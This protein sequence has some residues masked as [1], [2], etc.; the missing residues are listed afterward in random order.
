MVERNFYQKQSWTCV[1]VSISIKMRGRNGKV[2]LE[3]S[4]VCVACLQLILFRWMTVC[5]LG[6][7]KVYVFSMHAGI[8]RD[9]ASEDALELGLVGLEGSFVGLTVL[10]SWSDR[11]AVAIPS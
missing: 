11:G 6:F 3:G 9:K 5:L 2:K 1:H 4:I 8:V 7:Q 10:L